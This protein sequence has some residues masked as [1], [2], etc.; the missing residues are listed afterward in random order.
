MATKYQ[1]IDMLLKVGDGGGPETFTTLGASSNHT[2]S[3]NNAQIDVSDK[4]SN[5]WGELLAAGRRTMTITVEGLVSDDAQ[6]AIVEDNFQGDVIQNYQLVYGN[7]Q[8]I[9]GAFHI[10][11][12][13]VSGPSDDAQRF[14]LTL[15]NS[16]APTFS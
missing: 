10:D 15:T 8:T 11:S 12:A 3:I 2:L 16:G 9:E 5:R 13:E 7:S 4:D 14:S 1:G 6:W